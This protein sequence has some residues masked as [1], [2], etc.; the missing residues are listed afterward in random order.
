MLSC[1]IIQKKMVNLH[2]FLNT[3][4]IL[5]EKKQ[6]LNAIYKFKIQILCIFINE[7]NNLS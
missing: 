1:M 5:E 3:Q 4:V 6:N 2:D 7:P